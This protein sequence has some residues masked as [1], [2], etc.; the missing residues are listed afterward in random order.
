[1]VIWPASGGFIP[2]FR[3]KPVTLRER[4]AAL[5]KSGVPTLLRAAYRTISEAHN[6]RMTPHGQRRKCALL[7][8]IVGLPARHRAAQGTGRRSQETPCPRAVPGA[9]SHQPTHTLCFGRLGV[10]GATSSA[11]HLFRFFP[12][13]TGALPRSPHVP[14]TVACPRHSCGRWGRRANG[15]QHHHYISRRCAAP[16]PP[17]KEGEIRGDERGAQGAQALRSRPPLAEPV[18]PLQLLRAPSPRGQC[19]VLLQ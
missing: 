1:V 6:R 4:F 10:P 9:Q 5:R 11:M 17:A 14:L 13:L 15:A 8:P 16:L 3:P 12:T 18:H 2:A 19:T 7:G